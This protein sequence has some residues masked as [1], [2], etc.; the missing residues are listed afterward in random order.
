MLL[1]GFIWLTFSVYLFFR[2]R[3]QLLVIK[4]EEQ[5]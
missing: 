5:P 3:A 4:R 1:I 2:R